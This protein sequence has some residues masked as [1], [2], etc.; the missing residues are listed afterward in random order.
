M[1]SIPEYEW[2]TLDDEGNIIEPFKYIELE[3]LFE[4][5]LEATH[6]SEL[7]ASMVEE[8]DTEIVDAAV[9][10]DKDDSPE[11]RTSEEG[12]VALYDIFPDKPGLLEAFQDRLKNFN[13]DITT[14]PT[15]GM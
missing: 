4:N 10:W 3:F 12:G 9:L 15:R 1:P 2:E 14:W 6:I 5:E 8:F 11:I 13:V 7:I